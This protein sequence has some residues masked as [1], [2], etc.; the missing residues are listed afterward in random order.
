MALF[1]TSALTVS[2]WHVHMSRLSFPVIALPF[3]CTLAAAAI[4]LAMRSRSRIGWLIAGMMLGLGP[5]TYF[6]YPS[7]WLATFIVL[8]FYVYLQ[9]NRLKPSSISMAFFALGLFLALIPVIYNMAASPTVQTGRM[10][11]VWVFRSH[12]FP[13][14]EPFSQQAATSASA[15]GTR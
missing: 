14:D 12:E 8:A 7:F 4:L 6:A 1:A 9:R 10:G 5:Y 3:A 11:Q 15:Y 13:L 2:Y